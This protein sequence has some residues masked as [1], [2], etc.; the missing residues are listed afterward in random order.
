MT[1]LA[2]KMLYWLFALP[3]LAGLNSRFMIDSPL[4]VAARL[5]GVYV[6][7]NSLPECIACDKR[8]AH[9]GFSV[10]S[11]PDKLRASPRN[12]RIVNE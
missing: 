7:V 6:N 9:S 11:A 10:D 2:S 4:F 3:F 1:F 8:I 5:G 12:K